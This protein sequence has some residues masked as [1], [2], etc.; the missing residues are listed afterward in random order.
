MND[1]IVNAAED[2]NS[3]ETSPILLMF[4]SLSLSEKPRSL[5]KPNLML[6]PSNLKADLRRWRRCCSSAVAIVDW[7]DKLIFCD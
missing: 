4:S 2:A 6:S 7:F 3:L 1:V 5:F